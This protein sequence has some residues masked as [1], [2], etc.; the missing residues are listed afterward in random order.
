MV[1][2]P[3]SIRCLDVTHTFW[4][5]LAYEHDG[6]EAKA[7]A[8]GTWVTPR[9]PHRSVR[10]EL[11]HTA[12]ALSHDVR[13]WFGYGWRTRT[14]GIWLSTSRP[15]RSQV[16]RER[17]LRRRKACSHDRQTSAR[18]APSRRRFPWDGVIVQVSLNDSL[19]P[20]SYLRYRVM[21]VA[22]QVLADGL[23]PGAHAL[24][25]GKPP[26]SEALRPL[27]SPADVCEPQKVELLISAET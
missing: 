20:L 7:V 19:Q 16:I 17:W 23:Q 21:T 11:P 27:G 22:H 15:K 5:V 6:M 26:D 2:N 18:K 4:N 24:C 3:C 14:F 13:R 10:A 25:R 1:P 12:P 9:P 8:V